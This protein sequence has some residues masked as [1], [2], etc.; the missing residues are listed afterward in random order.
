MFKP[1]LKY[2]LSRSF[3]YTVK[4][5]Q[6]D[7]EGL[8]AEIMVHLDRAA[9]YRKRLQEKELMSF[10]I[11]ELVYDL[12]SPADSPGRDAPD[13]KVYDQIMDLADQVA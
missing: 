6:E 10:E 9:R 4:R 8:K 13:D 12:I 3:D 7:P 11:D 1:G 5:W 2:L